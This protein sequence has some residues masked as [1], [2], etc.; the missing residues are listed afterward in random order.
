MVIL[1]LIVLS[2][3]PPL[4]LAYYFYSKDIH[5]KEPVGLVVKSFVFGILSVIPVLIVEL[6]VSNQFENNIFLYALIGVALVEE[7]IKFYILK[8]FFFSRSEF[9]EP[10]D[11][12]VYAV[13]VSLGFAT[14]E[15]IFYVFGSFEDGVEVG[16]MRMFTAVPL[17][18]ACGVIMGYFVGLAKFKFDNQQSRLLWVG[19]FLAVVV[20]GIYDYFL[21]AGNYL[22]LA[23]LTLIIAMIFSNKAIKLHQ[24]NSPFR[25]G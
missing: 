3:G 5:E 16:I 25:K 17:H 12:I 8:R 9:N 23:I 18:A 6:I 19:L 20:H 21:F 10:F 11:G 15:N 14:I 24:D 7:G 22:A 4:A 2:I 13:M 1:I